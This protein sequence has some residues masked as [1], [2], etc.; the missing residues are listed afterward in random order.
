M[1]NKIIQFFNK[2][3]PNGLC[4]AGKTQPPCKIL[5]VNV[6][7]IVLVVFLLW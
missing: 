7:L 4:W 3:L 2:P 6:F 1:V 5:W